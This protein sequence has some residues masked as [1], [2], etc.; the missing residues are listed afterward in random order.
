MAWEAEIR[1]FRRDFL[2]YGGSLDGSG[3]LRRFEAPRDWIDQAEALKREETTPPG[4]VPMT[5]Y[6]YV[7]EA[8]RQIVGLIQI[9]RR[10]NEFLEK[11]GGHI[12]CSVCPASGE[13][14]MQ[15]RCCGSSCRNEG[16]WAS[17]GSWSAA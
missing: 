7:R 2:E 10:F 4:M 11:Y 6:I 13:R 1:A 17:A 15:R 3:S 9:R 12:G 5:Q 16:P 8:D 14:A